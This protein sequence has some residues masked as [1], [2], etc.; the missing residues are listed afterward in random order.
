MIG[1]PVR[2]KARWPR[3]APHVGEFFAS[4]RGRWIYRIVGIR[5]IDPRKSVNR[6]G[7]DLTCERWLP[8]DLPQDAIVNE[9]R[10]DG[11]KGNK[12]R[13]KARQR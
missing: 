11:R 3:G 10:R 1:E 7:F 12:N 2:I 5:R 9:W 6:Y 13:A 4:P 8:E